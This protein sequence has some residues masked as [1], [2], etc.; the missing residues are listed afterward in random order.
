MSLNE[1]TTVLADLDK[2]ISLDS[3]Y[4][5]AYTRKFN[6]LISLG[7][8]AMAEQTLEQI[9]QIDKDNS[10]IEQL[11]SWISA[12]KYNDGLYSKAID[13]GDY[14][15]ALH[16]CDNILKICT[17]S[18]SVQLKR[19]EALAHCLRHE[20]VIGIVDSILRKDGTNSEA[21]YI[22]GLSLYYQDNLEKA[23]AHFEKALKFEP[24][25]LKSIR[26]LKKARSFRSI[27]ENAKNAVNSCNLS[28][29]VE[30]YKEALNVDPTHRIGNAKVHFNLSIVYGRVRIGIG[31]VK[32]LESF[33]RLVTN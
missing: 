7:E 4:V 29:A 1:S 33:P 25:H 31:G 18:Q 21:F 9:R 12:V 28:Q 8:L 6:H 20:E 16:Y 22:R 26:Q 19:A 23:L 17:R 27:K 32:K 24:E 14:R 13:K 10:Q 2:A 3:S 11:A 15:E 30:L 5:K